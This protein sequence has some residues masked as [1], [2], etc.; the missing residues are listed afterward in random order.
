MCAR[1]QRCCMKMT[2]QLSVTTVEIKWS[3]ERRN[4]KPFVCYSDASRN[5]KCFALHFAFRA[6]H[7]WILA[8]TYS[9]WFL[10]FDGKIETITESRWLSRNSEHNLVGVLFVLKLEIIHFCSVHFDDAKYFQTDRYSE[11]LWFLHRIRL[12]V[13]EEWPWVFISISKSGKK[14]VQ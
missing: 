7:A 3:A 13:G 6:Q 11:I 12:F 9:R 2:A 4:K 10:Y 5:E 14:N 8:N 1:N